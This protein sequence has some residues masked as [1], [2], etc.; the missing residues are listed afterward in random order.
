MPYRNETTRRDN[1]AHP[2]CQ[3]QGRNFRRAD[4]RRNLA[5]EKPSDI[6]S[7]AEAVSAENGGGDCQAHL[8]P[9]YDFVHGQVDHFVLEDV[10]DFVP[11]QVRWN[12]NERTI[13]YG[14]GTSGI[15]LDYR[16]SAPPPFETLTRPIRIIDP[17]EACASCGSQNHQ[18]VGCLSASHNGLMLGC[19]LCNALTH[20]VKYCMSIQNLD[21]LQKVDLFLVKRANMPPFHEDEPWFRLF[22][23][24]FQLKPENGVPVRFP[25][26]R[27]FSQARLGDTARLQEELDAYHDQSRLPVDPATKDWPSVQAKFFSPVVRTNSLLTGPSLPKDQQNILAQNRQGFLEM[28]QNYDLYFTPAA[29][30]AMVARQ[31]MAAV[32]SEAEVRPFT[33]PLWKMT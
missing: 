3:N 5:M 2:Y 1:R 7:A 18:L 33:A 16:V 12:T 10:D 32:H 23:T 9:V 30:Q 17:M 22:K 28:V 25:W 21:L 11:G 6:G 20:D 24:Y 4:A 13:P 15:S 31:A 29:W 8:M 14:L 19:P 26:S 27:E